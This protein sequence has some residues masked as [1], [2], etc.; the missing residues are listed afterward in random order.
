MRSQ[1]AVPGAV[2][3]RRERVRQRIKGDFNWV[4]AFA[5]TVYIQDTDLAQ[6]R[7]SSTPSLLPPPRDRYHTNPEF[8]TAVLTSPPAVITRQPCSCLYRSIRLSIRDTRAKRPLVR[9]GQT[10]LTSPRRPQ[11]VIS[12]STHTS[13]TILLPTV[14]SLCTRSCSNKHHHSRSLANTAV[15]WS[16]VSRCG[17]MQP[18]V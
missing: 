9:G 2:R 3:C 15:P 7:L 5:E 17:M 14:L 12:H 8:L 10:K 6:S 18:S 1:C 4:P 11:L 16:R 13:S